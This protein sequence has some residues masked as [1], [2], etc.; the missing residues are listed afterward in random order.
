MVG[1]GLA[2]VAGKLLEGLLFGI[3]AFDPVTLVMVP[4]LLLGVAA[5]AAYLPARR[6]GRIDPITALKAE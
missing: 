3:R 2:L 1:I 4:V 5:V 6:A